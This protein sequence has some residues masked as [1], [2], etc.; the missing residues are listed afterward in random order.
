MLVSIS[1]YR[2]NCLI[3]SLFSLMRINLCCHV[4]RSTHPPP[5]IPLPNM[6]ELLHSYGSPVV[7]QSRASSICAQRSLLCSFL[8]IQL[9]IFSIAPVQAYLKDFNNVFAK[10]DSSSHMSCDFQSSRTIR[11]LHS[12]LNLSRS[13]PEMENLCEGEVEIRFLFIAL[14][15]SIYIS[16]IFL[17]K[18]FRVVIAGG[19]E[20]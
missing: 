9:S 1:L 14:Q 20:G 4:R 2:G 11:L 7:L 10:I 5:T 8:P 15:V 17:K 12:L 13:C 18:E 6:L 19:R 16:V 3:Q